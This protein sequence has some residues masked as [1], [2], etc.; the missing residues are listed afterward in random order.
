[1]FASHMDQAAL[2]KAAEAI[3]ELL[4]WQ[5]FKIAH[6]KVDGDWALAAATYA[7]KAYLEEAGD[8]PSRDTVTPCR[9]FQD[10]RPV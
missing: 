5:A 4:H 3:R 6:E 2:D 7:V 1:M 10:A 9:V 8:Q